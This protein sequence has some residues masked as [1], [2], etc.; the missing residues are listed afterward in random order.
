VVYIIFAIVGF[1]TF[2]FCKRFSVAITVGWMMSM[3]GT[4]VLWLVEGLLE[5]D[6]N[7]WIDLS[8]IL[9]FGV[10]GFIL[11]CT[12]PDESIIIGSAFAGA[13]LVCFG[14]G[15][16]LS[17]YPTPAADQERWVWWTY[18]I[19]QMLLAVAGT[20]VQCGLKKKKGYTTVEYRSETHRELG[21]DFQ[22]EVDVQA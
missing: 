1:L 21:L 2:L 6:L 20:V 10:V 15:I 5:Q 19:V 16:M 13:T 4:N 11:G 8:I 9:G 17:Q 18:F 22:V 12:I 7:N 3:L 14:V